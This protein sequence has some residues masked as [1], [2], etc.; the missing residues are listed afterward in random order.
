MTGNSPAV[1]GQS[2][3]ASTP[4]EKEEI[5]S[6][7]GRVTIYPR[8]PI[9]FPTGML[10]M[11]D[12][13]H[14]CLTH[15]PS[16]RMARFKLLQSLDDTSLSFLTLPVDISNPI[17]ERADLEQA[18]HDLE[19]PLND[20]AMLLVVTVHRE[21]GVAKLSVNARAPVLMNITRRVA[22]QYVFPHSKYLIR[23]P[24]AL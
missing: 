1:I 6:R 19:M 23:Q 18:A 13:V 22:A 15:L 16:E 5:D 2:I 4:P 11:P 9:S 3:L 17:I 8:N 10:G 12:K 21:S 20:L 24:L 14:F 7:F